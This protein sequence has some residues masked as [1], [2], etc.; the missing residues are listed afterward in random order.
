MGTIGIDIRHAPG[1]GILADA[2]NLPLRTESVDVVYSNHALEHFGHREVESVLN[3][4]VRVLKRKGTIEI[5]CPDLRI[6]SL[7]FFLFPSWKNIKNIYGEQDHEGN[8]HK[9]GFSF[10]L[11]KGLLKACGITKVSRIIDGFRGIP[12]IPSCLRVLIHLLC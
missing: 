3:E 2:R 11:L 7:L 6:R 12:F 1:V 10:E 5:S 9:S 8:Y 4:W